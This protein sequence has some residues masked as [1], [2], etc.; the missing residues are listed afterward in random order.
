[1]IQSGRHVMWVVGAPLILALA[2][3]GCATKKYVKNQ[4]APVNA[5]VSQLQTQ[6]NDQI[7]YLHNQQQADM[8]RMESQMSE[9]SA[10]VDQKISEVSSAAEQ[11]QGSASR[12]MEAST[13]N[14]TRIDETNASVNALGVGVANALNY[15][16][17]EKAD[18]TFG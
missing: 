17:V 13:A 3:S 12:A 6:T 5:K 1:M 8:S 2:S 9:R 14:S 4:V 16:E 11:A 7:S 15:Q 10:T 18:V